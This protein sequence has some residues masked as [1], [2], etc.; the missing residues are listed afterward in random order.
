MKLTVTAVNVGDKYPPEY[1]YILHRMVS[2]HLTL[3]HDFIVFTDDVHKFRGA[4]FE[5]RQE[6]TGLPGWWSKLYLFHPE[7][8]LSGRVLYLDEDLVLVRNIDSLIADK[9][10]WIIRDWLNPATYNSSVILFSAEETRDFWPRFTWQDQGIY[11]TDQDWLAKKIKP[12]TLY[13]NPTEVVSYKHDRCEEALPPEAK[14][15]VF[16]GYPKP[17]QVGGWVKDYWY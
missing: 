8:A 11:G 14:I 16:H 13:F 7:S 15:V 17:H 12:E 2:R 3:P 10:F 6:P 9:G 1:L 5:V 4:P